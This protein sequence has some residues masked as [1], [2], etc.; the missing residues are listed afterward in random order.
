M[1]LESAPLV[2]LEIQKW[3]RVGLTRRCTDSLPAPARLIAMTFN[4]NH[5]D[6]L[7]IN[8]SIRQYAV[9]AQS[10]PKGDAVVRETLHVA[11]IKVIWTP[12]K[13]S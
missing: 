1:L 13:T 10:S 7:V 2:H 12:P 6:P 8:V 5:L 9:L 3:L 11:R 4:R